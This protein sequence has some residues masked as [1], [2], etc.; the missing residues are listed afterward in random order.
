MLTLWLVGPYINPVVVIPTTGFTEEVPGK[1]LINI[2]LESELWEYFHN[3]P[4]HSS[5]VDEIITIDTN[6]TFDS[7]EISYSKQYAI[8]AKGLERKGKPYAH[9]SK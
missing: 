9:T 5:W 8:K 4:M 2:Y 7:E 1:R 6:Y 3:M